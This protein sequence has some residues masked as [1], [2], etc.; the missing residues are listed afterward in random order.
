MNQELQYIVKDIEDQLKA[1]KI[2]TNTDYEY[3]RYLEQLHFKLNKLNNKSLKDYL[4]QFFISTQNK[5][6]GFYEVLHINDRDKEI[7]LKQ[8][9]YRCR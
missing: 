1:V 3:K 8:K 4:N 9:K 7:L 6:S 2:K 5:A